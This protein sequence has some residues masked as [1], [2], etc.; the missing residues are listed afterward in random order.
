LG[1]GENNMVETIIY[2][3][4]SKKIVRE[5]ALPYATDFW[6]GAWKSY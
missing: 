5:L 2:T 4:P 3:K 6:A 1:G